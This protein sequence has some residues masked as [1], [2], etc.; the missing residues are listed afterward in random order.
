MLEQTF[1]FYQ[2]LT[3]KGVLFCSTGPLNQAVIENLATTLRS[4]VEFKDGNSSL[5]MKVLSIF[6]EQV[7]NIV[8]YSEDRMIKEIPQHTEHGQGVCII[9]YEDE[10]YYIISGNR[11]RNEDVA[12]IEAKIA[13]LRTMD[14]AALKAYFFEQRKKGPDPFSKGAGL[15]LIDM[16]RRGKEMDYH[17][18]PVDDRFTFF[19]IKVVV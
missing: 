8:R 2:Q 14:Q 1:D 7:Q 16:V 6:V 17:F 19:V 3:N 12:R 18:H 15:G 9:G 5:A 4:K 13:V 10:H 11:I